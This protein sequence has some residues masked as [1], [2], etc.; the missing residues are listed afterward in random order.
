MSG[1]DYLGQRPGKEELRY[2]SMTAEMLRGAWLLAERQIYLLQQ[3]LDRIKEVVELHHKA[4]HELH[5]GSVHRGTGRWDGKNPPQ[6]NPPKADPPSTPIA[7]WGS[8]RTDMQNV[9]RDGTPV[10]FTI[11]CQVADSPTMKLG[12]AFVVRARWHAGHWLVVGFK[13]SDKERQE[14]VISPDRP[15]AWML[16]PKP[17]QKA[18]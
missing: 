4:E 7:V 1:L 16:A 15:Y 9:P 11:D 5:L 18:G 2:H 10:L 13:P 3:E 17:H 6:T 12:E 14:I 8:W